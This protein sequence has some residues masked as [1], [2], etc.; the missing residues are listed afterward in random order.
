MDGN[1]EVAAYL[2]KATE[3]LAGA[4]SEYD[5]GRFNNSA[6]RAYYAAF[7]AAIAA[8]LME[9]IRSAGEQWPHTFVQS[10][11]S[12]KLVGRRHRYPSTLGDALPELETLRLRADYRRD[13]ISEREAR[14][15]LRRCH[16]FV[17]AVQSRGVPRQ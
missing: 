9:S 4:Q 7:Q 3:S 15:G 11:F 8:L 14:R 16:E 13:T 12:G 5:N 10:E 6:N 17:E 2:A 1:P